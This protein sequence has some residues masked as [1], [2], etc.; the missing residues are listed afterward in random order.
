MTT[1][2]QRNMAFLTEEETLFDAISLAAS[3]AWSSALMGC[4]GFRLARCQMFYTGA[5]SASGAYVELWPNGSTQLA[6]PVIGDNV[7]TSLPALD[8]SVTVASLGSGTVP[9]GWDQTVVASSFGQVSLPPLILKPYVVAAATNIVA[10]SALIDVTGLRW[11]S[12]L[13][14]ERG[15]TTHPGTLTIKVTLV[16]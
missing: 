5:A 11:F 13:A 16:A 6:R 4:A 10:Q 8:G 2:S 1:A 9:T 12:I 7:W 15:D 14:H 3:G